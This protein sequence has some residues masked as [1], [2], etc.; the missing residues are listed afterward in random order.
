MLLKHCTQYVSKFGK[1]SNG[2]RL[3]NVSFHSIPK[4]GQYQ[5]MFELLNNCIQFAC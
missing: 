4:E 3:E 1:L 5:I 2:H